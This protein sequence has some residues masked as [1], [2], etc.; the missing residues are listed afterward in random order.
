MFSTPS[1][2]TIGDEYDK[3]AGMVDRAQGKQMLTNK[4]PQVL[5]QGFASLSIGDKYI[6]P[7]T[8]EKR[9][10]LELSKKKLTPE[11]FKYTNP[12]K[13][14]VGLG[15]YYGTFSERAPFK[16]ETE[17]IVLKKG[18]IPGKQQAQQRNI[19]TSPPKKGTYGT[20]GI[21]ISLGDEYK[22][23]SDPYDAAKRKEAEAAKESNHK[24]IGPAFKGACKR[25][26]Y[27]DSQPNV[28]A[29]RIYTLDQPLPARKPEPPKKEPAI[30]VPFKPSSPSKRG[31]Q[32][33][34][35]KFPEYKEDPYEA[36]QRLEREERQ[37][38]KTAVTWKPVSGSRSLPTRS[39]AFH[40]TV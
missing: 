2:T 11:G 24:S 30:A 15:N 18:E 9:Q 39:I 7:G 19:T 12:G 4:K 28:A 26:D 40:K 37:K 21:T 34:L 36:R 23:I 33:L 16:H 35:T 5:G 25:L 31:V 29:S 27:F 20:P 3:K 1:Y 32:G 6:D 14:S 8:L 17:Y 13:K 10:R 22:Y 38:N